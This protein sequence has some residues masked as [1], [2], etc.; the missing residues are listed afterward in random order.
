M[1]AVKKRPDQ[2]FGVKVCD[3]VSGSNV[4][5]LCSTTFCTLLQ[6]SSSLGGAAALIEVLAGELQCVI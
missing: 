6:A 3:S 2:L 5:M 4:K 1:S